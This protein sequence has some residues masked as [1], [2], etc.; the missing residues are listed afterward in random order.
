MH[1]ALSPGRSCP[2]TPSTWYLKLQ[3]DFKAAGLVVSK[4]RGWI[5]LPSMPPTPHHKQHTNGPWIKAVKNLYAQ[6]HTEQ[7]IAI[8]IL[9][10]DTPA[11]QYFKTL[12]L[13]IVDMEG[14]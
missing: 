11:A 2:S 14:W 3:T 13:L 5:R 7:K 12:F 1:A 10:C 9:K 8:G 6:P 4:A